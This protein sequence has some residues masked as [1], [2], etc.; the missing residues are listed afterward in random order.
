MDMHLDA[1]APARHVL[2][3]GFGGSSFRLAAPAGSINDVDQLDGQTI[4]T[5]YAGCCSPGW[6]PGTSPRASCAWTVRWRML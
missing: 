1:G 2:D 5:S 4:A 6:I 3:L